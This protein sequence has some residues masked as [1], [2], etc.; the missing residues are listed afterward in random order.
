MRVG[1][2]LLIGV[3]AM[4]F[5]ARLLGR[6]RRALGVTLLAVG[7]GTWTFALYFGAHGAELF[8]LGVGFA[9]AAL[10]VLAAGWLAA[11]A[12]SDAA[13]AVAIATGLAAPLAF[14]GGQGT[15][16]SLALYFAVLL[17][18]QIAAHIFTATGGG[19]RLSRG[20]ALGVLWLVV[21]SAVISIR[22]GAPEY[23]LLG[24]A[25][26][27][28]TA[29]VLAWLPRQDEEPWLPAGGSL[30]ALAGMAVAM[31]VVW[32]RAGW[33]DERFSLA[34]AALAAVALGLVF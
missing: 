31:F 17:G 16:A 24:L 18:A 9:G 14:S 5:A 28:A 29:L 33:T 25:A 1:A 6:E 7:T 13:M 32:R 22:R 3:A 2:G 30:A 27:G 21:W 26:L 12:G 11:R 19:W 34:L 15:V 4:V 23:A 20:L 8:P 10:A